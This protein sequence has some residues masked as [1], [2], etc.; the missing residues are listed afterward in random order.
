MK[1]SSRCVVAS[2]LAIGAGMALV[3]GDTAEAQAIQSLNARIVAVNIPGASAIAQVGTFL[4]DPMAC[5]RPIPT[6][7]PSFTQ[8]GAMLDPKRLLVGSQSNFGAPLAT[9]DVGQEGSFLSIDPSGSGHSQCPVKFRAE[10][11]SRVSP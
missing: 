4:S 7:F 5:A 8:P 2:V 10:G 11:R 6:L 9:G 3:S 1:Q